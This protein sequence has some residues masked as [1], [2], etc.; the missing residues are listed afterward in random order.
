MHQVKI[1]DPDHF[2]YATIVSK[3]SKS[4]TRPIQ[5]D[6]LRTNDCSSSKEDISIITPQSPNPSTVPFGLS[7]RPQSSAVLPR[8]P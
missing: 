6:S 7:R 8:T 3:D 2:H 4:S 5:L 1:E